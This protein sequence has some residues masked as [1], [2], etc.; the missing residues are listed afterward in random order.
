MNAAPSTTPAA[1]L[2]N[3]GRDL[4]AFVLVITLAVAACLGLAFLGMAL[5]GR[6][7]LRE[8]MLDRARTD[9]RMILQFQDWSTASNSSPKAPGLPSPSAATAPA[10]MTR[11]LSDRQNL[12]GGFRFHLTSL[13]PI[14]PGNK[15][16]PEEA[17]ALVAFERGVKERTWDE[18]MGGRTFTRY[19]APLMVEPS[20]LECHAEQGY[21]VGEIRGGIS[22][23]YD[24]QHLKDK[25]RMTLLLVGLLS[26]LT[27]GLMLSLVSLLF[28][29]L[30]AKRAG[31]PHPLEFAAVTDPLT[32]LLNRSHL[33]ERFDQECG[34][35]TRGGDGLCC[36]LLDVDRFK[37]VNAL[38]GHQAG[39]VVLAQIAAQCRTTLRAYDVLGRYGGEAFLAMLPRTSL[40]TARLVA[41]RLREAIEAGESLRKPSGERYPISASLGLSEWKPFDTVDTLI[42]RAEEAL[43][44]AKKSGRNCIAIVDP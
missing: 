27:A 26:L 35:A 8:E 38:F 37:E 18:I 14:H 16:D 42:H 17:E 28:R 34:R 9:F 22:L 32:G 41:E 36:I 6:A 4:K 44:H 29:H 25:L 30:V 24:A 43:Y 7:L 12:S 23:S 40:A 39:D 31:A 10:R 3:E 13:R 19:M 21:R 11:D 20:C 1:S 15:A 33:L 5:R 2:A